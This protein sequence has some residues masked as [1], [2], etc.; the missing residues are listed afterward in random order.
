MSSSIV[1]DN[2]KLTPKISNQ[3]KDLALLGTSPAALHFK[4]EKL[5]FRGKKVIKWWTKSGKSDKNLENSI[6]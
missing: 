1:Q 6:R 5:N 2:E 3:V 4:N